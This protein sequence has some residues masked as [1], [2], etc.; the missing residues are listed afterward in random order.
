MEIVLACG[1]GQTSGD[2]SGRRKLLSK[3]Y[4]SRRGNTHHV[5]V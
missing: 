5:S 1:I 2:F 3:A 4:Q